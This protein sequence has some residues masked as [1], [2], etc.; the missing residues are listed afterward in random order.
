VWSSAAVAHLLQGSTC[1]AFRDALL[2]TL[3]VT[4]GYL[5]YCYRH[6]GLKQLNH[7]PLTSG[8]NKAF[9]AENCHSLDI[10][11]AHFG[12]LSTNWASFK[13]HNLPEY[14]CWPCLSLYDHSVPSSDAASSRITHHVTKLKSSQTSFLNTTMSSLYSNGFHSHQISIQ[15]STFGMWWNGRF[16]SWICNRQICSNCVMLP[17]QYWPKSQRNV[18]STLLNL[19]HE[20]LRQFRRQKGIQ[21]GT[22]KVYLI[23]W[24]V[25]VC[26]NSHS[27][28]LAI[29]IKK[30]ATGRSSS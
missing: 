29:V 20:E 18:S 11:V 16:A 10:F 3:V 8:I 2:Q 15:Q 9:S 22:S 17:Y 28:P 7:F 14:C 27:A 4:S 5:S 23:K 25:S 21:A 12:P 6:I 30:K 24:H 1:C 13:F 26:H 19:Y